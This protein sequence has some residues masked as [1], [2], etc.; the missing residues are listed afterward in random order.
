MKSLSAT[1][2]D[3]RAV[4]KTAV[5]WPGNTGAVDGPGTLRS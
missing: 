3:G 4:V 5:L 1:L 2:S